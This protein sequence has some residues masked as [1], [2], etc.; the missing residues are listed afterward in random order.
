MTMRRSFPV[1]VAGALAAVIL[2]QAAARARLRAAA[3]VLE[4]V[5]DIPLPGG[6]S[7][8]D[9][10]SFDPK[11]GRLYIS[12]MGAGRLVV[13]D[14]KARKVVANLG[15]FP[16]VTGVLFV[17][18]M[19]RVYASA[20]GSHQ[21]VV[22]DAASLKRLARVS[23]AEF[24]D[25]LAY[26]AREQKVFVSDESGRADLVIDARSN[27]PLGRIPLGGEAGN[28]QFDPV[29]NQIFVAVQ[30][31]NEMAAIDPKEQ[32]VVARYPL[33][34][35]DHPHGFTLDAPARLMF[36]S[37]EGNAK[38]LVVDMHTMKVTSVQSVGGGPDVLAFDPGLHRLYVASESGVVSVFDEKDG[39]LEKKG[40][41]RA[42]D[43]HSIAVDPG[44]HRVYLPLKHLKGRPVLRVMEPAPTG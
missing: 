13:F 9:Y 26:A 21:V 16:T 10:Q 29:S 6:T 35:S 1:L 5:A 8:F 11:T 18:E 27:R 4:Q 7:R 41:I 42:P 12:H 44:T 17:P 14:T 23:G 24:P 22:V 43:A 37:C 25:G 34:G 31:R 2:S 32:R 19:N 39:G 36:V 33:P 28:T 20:A 40:E 15:G 3:P 30:T 38:L